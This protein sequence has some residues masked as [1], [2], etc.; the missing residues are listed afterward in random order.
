MKIGPTFPTVHYPYNSVGVDG[1]DPL[2]IRSHQ[3]VNVGLKN[4]KTGQGG[5]STT[6]VGVSLLDDIQ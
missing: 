3:L 1:I 6:S 4:E 2:L 5:E